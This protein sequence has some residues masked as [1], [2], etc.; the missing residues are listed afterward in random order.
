MPGEPVSETT[1]Y[2][3]LVL[4]W[5]KIGDCDHIKLMLFAISRELFSGP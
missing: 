1:I 3:R 5:G 2:R 4:I